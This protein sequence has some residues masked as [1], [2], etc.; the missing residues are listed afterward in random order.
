MKILSYFFAL[1]LAPLVAVHAAPALKII[2]VKETATLTFPADGEKENAVAGAAGG[3]IV[4]G[5]PLWSLDARAYATLPKTAWS[6][7][8]G[9]SSPADFF[10]LWNDIRYGFGA[11]ANTR[12]P[13]TVKAGMLGFSK[14]V[15]RLNT[16][17]PSAS[18]N[19]LTKSFGFSAG[20]GSNLPTLSSAVKPLAVFASVSVPQKQFRFPLEVQCAWNADQTALASASF[21]ARILPLVTVQSVCTA[22]HFVVSADSATKKL[23]ADTNAYFTE[24]DLFAASWESAFRSPFVKANLFV[25]FHQTPFDAEFS[26][27]SVW[28]KAAARSTY[29]NVLVD[30]SYFTIPT[31]SASPRPVPLIGGSATICRTISQLGINPQVQ[32]ALHNAYAAT[33][34]L[35]FHAVIEK[36]ILNTLS[37]EQYSTLKW[38]AGLAYESKPF[39]AKLTFTDTN[40]ILDGRFLTVSTTP[41]EYYSADVTTS[42]A[43]PA[44]RASVSLGYDR[45]PKSVRTGSTKDHF[46]VDASATPGKARMVTYTAGASASYK[47]GEKTSA[48]VS[49][50]ATV[51]LQSRWV[52][53]TLKCAISVPL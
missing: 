40:A 31:L 17:A 6:A 13:V 38:S 11:T 16:P 9:V 34:R 29:R 42:L 14:S 43:L 25:G 36:K 8:D 28:I 24:A 53:T 23:L 22:A 45:H 4:C 49:T 18:A 15:S 33:L 3:R 2:E 44:V 37:A 26:S 39:T 21:F 35:G 48:S 41:D 12:F 7:F 19:P 10:A 52:R 20:I 1:A 51:R 30:V 46:S 5:S 50:S 27:C 47:D 32:F